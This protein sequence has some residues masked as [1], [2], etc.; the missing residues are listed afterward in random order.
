MKPTWMKNKILV[1]IFKE[2][3]GQEEDQK[4]Y[5]RVLPKVAASQATGQNL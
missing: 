5:T 1:Q 4:N 2:K 3:S